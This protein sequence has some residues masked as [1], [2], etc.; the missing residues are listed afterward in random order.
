MKLKHIFLS[1]LT[2]SLA[3][4]MFSCGDKTVTPS[5]TY[6][7]KQIQKDIETSFR[8]PDGS[9]GFIVN[10]RDDST[11]K[12]YTTLQTY[13]RDTDSFS[14]ITL[15]RCFE[16]KF[17]LEIPN[18]TATPD[19]GYFMQTYYVSYEKVESSSSD[20]KTTYI[21]ETHSG[22]TKYDSDGN[23][24][25][26]KYAEEYQT[27]QTDF[28]SEDISYSAKFPKIV[29]SIADNDGN[30]YLICKKLTDYDPK[31]FFATYENCIIVIS[32]DGELICEIPQSD[33]DIYGLS[34]CKFALDSNGK[35]M[36]I[37]NDIGQ[38]Y[39]RYIDLENKTVTSAVPTYS[40][41]HTPYFDMNGNYYYATEF[42]LFTTSADENGNIESNMVFDWIST[43]LSRSMIENV[44]IKDDS[45]ITIKANE[46]DSAVY[47]HIKKYNAEELPDITTLTVAMD[48]LKI[49]SDTQ[50]VLDALGKFNRSNDTYRAVMVSYSSTEGGLSASQKLARDIAS[51]N[52]PDLIV[53]NGDLSYDILKDK[54]KFTD[55]YKYLDEDTEYG[56]DELLPAVYKPFETKHGDLNCIGTTYYNY[57]VSADTS[58]TGEI[59]GYTLSD[60]LEINNSLSD[61]EYFMALSFT[62][63]ESASNT[64]LSDIL[65]KMLPEFIDRDKS[66]CDFDG[67]SE[68]LEICKT[69]KLFNSSNVDI[70]ILKD[71]KIAF[72]I[73]NFT[74][75]NSFYSSLALGINNKTNVGFP[76]T[77]K[78]ESESAILVLS[79]VCILKNCENKDKGWEIIRDTIINVEKAWLTIPNNASLP[80]SILPTTYTALDAM[81]NNS[82]KYNAGINSHSTINFYSVFSQINPSESLTYIEFT[83]ENNEYLTNSIENYSRTIMQLGELNSIIKEEASYYF[84]NTKSLDE[85][86]KIITD[87]VETYLSE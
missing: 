59:D 64:L 4:L 23:A 35:V 82:G 42:G 81:N 19:G 86:I 72:E 20:L 24:V 16:K 17:N 6:L 44:I 29:N 39:T 56:R 55:L 70:D 80:T 46:D 79:S 9:T 22:F 50:Y 2:V 33:T 10:E 48:G 71:T 36:I 27:F 21:F 57:T 58:I 84:S 52:S 43:G 28:D 15:E 47:Y 53:F 18:V 76:G 41:Y 61:D 78:T 26:F 77:K 8:L 25:F 31:S 45:D 5:Y 11:Q 63:R 62:D 83:K 7:S 73:N 85:V 32:S 75:I 87:R 49:T 60:M 66:K 74:S 34:N 68:L 54:I 40:Q 69:A 3:F 67:L 30:I 13:D 65:N 37:E 1:L 12:S 38:Y 14:S 51:G